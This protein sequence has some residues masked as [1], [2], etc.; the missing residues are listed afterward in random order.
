MQNEGKSIKVIEALEGQLITNT[1]IGKAKVE[2]ENLVSNV[3]DDILKI[4]VI[5]RYKK[6]LL[7][8]LHL[9]KILALNGGVPLPPRWLMTATILL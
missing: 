7:R 8:Q 3:A 9:S 1:F 6:K 2:G 5:N 4:A